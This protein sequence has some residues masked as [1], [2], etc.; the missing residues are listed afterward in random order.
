MGDSV[1]DHDGVDLEDQLWGQG[2]ALIG[3]AFG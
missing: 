1:D 3:D 2:E